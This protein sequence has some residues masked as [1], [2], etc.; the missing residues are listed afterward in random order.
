MTL[1]IQTDVLIVGTSMGGVAAALACGDQQ[2]RVVLLSVDEQDI[3][4]QMTTQGVSA[5]D[6]HPHIET[7][8]GTASYIA[9]REG[10]RSYYARQYPNANPQAW[11]NPGNGW[12]SRLCFEPQVGV[13][14]LEQLL[15]PYSNIQRLFAQQLLSVQRNGDSLYSVTYQNTDGQTVEVFAHYFLDATDSG[16][17]L[18]LSETPFV[19]GAESFAM[20]GELDAPPDYRPHENQSFTLCFFMQYN[21]NEHQPILRPQHYEHYRDTQPFSLTLSN[22]S[23][24][25]TTYPFFDGELSFWA[26]RRVLDTQYLGMPEKRDIALINWAGNDYY[27]RNLIN[28]SPQERT[29]A[30]HEATELSL[31]FAYWLQHEVPRDDGGSGYPELQLLSVCSK[32]YLRESRRIVAHRRITSHDIADDGTRTTTHFKDSVGLGWY[33]MDLH[34]CVGNPSVSRYQATVPFQ[35]PLGALIGAHTRNLIMACKNIGTTHLSNGAYRLHPI[36]WNIGESAGALAIF[37]LENH[38]EPSEVWHNQIQL[39]QFQ[40]RLLQQGIPLAWTLDTPRHH[41][42]FITRQQRA[43]GE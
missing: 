37:C 27:G 36:E 31:S 8:G 7:F 11:R 24:G 28:V 33:A 35:I 9:L 38:T 6:E 17:L 16:E 42:D 18:Y 10:I 4:G 12:V 34:A 14:I 1:A 23:G 43:I 40:H 5:F 21:P 41:A 20:T 19:S 22:H 26:Y 25:Q 15:A 39:R 13:Q 2:Q 30:L 29:L 32:P 3:G